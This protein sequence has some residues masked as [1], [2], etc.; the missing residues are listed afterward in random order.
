MNNKVVKNKIKKLYHQTLISD[1]FYSL[2]ILDAFK[3][4][5]GIDLKNDN[6]SLFDWTINYINRNT[7]SS[8]EY[9]FLKPDDSILPEAIS[10]F[11]LEAALLKKDYLESVKHAYYL[12]KVSEGTQIFEFLLEFSLIRC[13][14]S[15]K[16]IWHIFRMSVFFNNEFIFLSLCKMIQSIVNDNYYEPSHIKNK[17]NINWKDYLSVENQNIND[18]LLYFSISNAKLIRSEKISKSISHRIQRTK[19]HK[20]KE[21]DEKLVYKEQRNLGRKWISNHLFKMDKKEYSFEIIVLMNNIRSCLKLSK[22]KKEQEYFWMHLNLYLG[23][24]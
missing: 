3:S 19:S 4:I 24:I 7:K 6:T 16:Y 2:I 12:S 15:F 20:N 5:K 11:S 13:K 14:E 9:N 10:Y 8:S 1:N 18:L 23:K 22:T 17:T 21:L